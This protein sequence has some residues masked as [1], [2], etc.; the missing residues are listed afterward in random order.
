MVCEEFVAFIEVLF[1]HVSRQFLSELFDER[2]S[3]LQQELSIKWNACKF[4]SLIQL[5]YD[6]L[7]QLLVNVD[8]TFAAYL[9]YLGNRHLILC[10]LNFLEDGL[11]NLRSVCFFHNM[12][13]NHCNLLKLLNTFLAFLLI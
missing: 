1:Y 2:D 8:V 4:A 12:E 9:D 13:L 7:F 5:S 11:L 10:T 6:I 3:M